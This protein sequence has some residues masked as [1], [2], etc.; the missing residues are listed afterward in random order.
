MQISFDNGKPNFGRG[1]GW[2][3]KITMEGMFFQDFQRDGIFYPLSF[4]VIQKG[5]L[6]WLPCSVSWF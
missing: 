3:D 1:M 6:G 2:V 5:R 4:R